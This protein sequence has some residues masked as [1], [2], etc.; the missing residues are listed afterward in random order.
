MQLIK[1]VE[2]VLWHIMNNE[3]FREKY[4]KYMGRIYAIN[5]GYLSLYLGVAHYRS[6][7]ITY[8]QKA[9]KKDVTF[10]FSRNFLASLKFIL[11][12]HGIR[13]KFRS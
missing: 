13:G 10:V 9:V 6:E 1:R 11:G 3:I 8:L 5:Y 2:K 4:S 7:A 12:L